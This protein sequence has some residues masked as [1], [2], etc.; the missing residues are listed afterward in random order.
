[1]LLQD[2][3]LPPAADSSEIFW[4]RSSSLLREGV[5]H[6]DC[7]LLAN[8]LPSF[9]CRICPILASSNIF[10]GFFFLTGRS[11]RQFLH[12]HFMYISHTSIKFFLLISEGSYPNLL[13]LAWMDAF[14]NPWASFLKYLLV[15]TSPFLT[16][17]MG[18]RMAHQCPKCVHIRD[19]WRVIKKTLQ[20][21]CSLSS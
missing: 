10:S 13:C 20:V 8:K 17:E 6:L 5:I 1:M 18:N 11:S 16:W 15:A 19:L 9:L 14:P 21:V 2:T 4:A 12:T 3:G 7:K